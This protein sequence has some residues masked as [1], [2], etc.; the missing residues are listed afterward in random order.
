MKFNVEKIAWIDCI[1]SP[2]DD[3][4][5]ITI[6]IISKAWSI[7]E[8]KEN[9]GISHFLEHLFFKWG[10]KYTTPQ[11][12][13]EAVDSFGGEFN[14]YTSNYYAG[15]YV[16]C[17][18]N[19]VHKA[20][21]VL[22]DMLVNAQFPKEELERE[23]W[24][25]IQEIKMKE[26]NPVQLLFDK[27]KTYY[28]G[29]NSFGRSTLWPE[30]NILKFTQEDLFK[31][32]KDLYSKDNLIISIAGKITDI[33]KV[34][35]LLEE[36]FKDLPESKDITEPQYAPHKPEKKE[37]FYDKGTEQNHLI[38]AADGFDGN[39]DQRYAASILATILW[40]NMSSR[41]FQNI[42]EKE[43]LCYYITAGHYDN[44]HSG[45]FAIR[46]GIDKERFEFGL[47]KIYEE[48]AKI[49]EWDITQEEF[50]KAI[51]YT[52][53]QIQMGIETTDEMCSFV[54]N[55]HLLYG[56]IKSLEDILAEY[57]KLTLEDIKKVATKL[58]KDNL[59]LYYIK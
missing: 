55:Q 45:F 14:A 18:P 57:N 3:T 50:D 31:H 53:W 7:Y 46:A 20:I 44:P 21:D 41:L 6:E 35:K 24:V 15:Y 9:N 42:R 19:F 28:Y 49:A 39:D 40:W 58:H 4:N 51:G 29:D 54:G 37:D 48:I 32:K 59:Y 27:W 10:K 25:V 30:E 33:E 43:G 22:S 11:A 12:V 52:E 2:M 5:S 34:K 16:K 56:E 26:D 17:A 23:K 13:A 47:E 38:I 36:S 1:F 8:T